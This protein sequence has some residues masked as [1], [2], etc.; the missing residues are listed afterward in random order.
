[1]N[2]VVALYLG[3]DGL[4]NGVVYA[5]LAVA[6]VV[7]FSVT[8]IMFVPQGEFVSYGALTFVALQDGK[9][10]GTIALLGL[11]LVLHIDVDLVSRGQR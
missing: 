10:P 9:R 4:A 7:L 3:Q 6:I 5:L 8:R 2:T 11:L 1:M